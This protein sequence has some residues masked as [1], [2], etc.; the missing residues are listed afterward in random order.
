[1]TRSLRRLAV[2]VAAATTAGLLAAP[3]AAAAE[4]DVLT[5]DFGATTGAFRG[6]ASGT[7]YG[8]GDDGSPTQ[9]LINGAH[10][11]N[12]SQKPP[13]GLQHP[14][15]DALEIEDGF[16]DKHGRELAVYVQ[17]FYPDWGYHGAVRPQDTRTYDQSDG[18]WTEGGNG[19]W[20]YLEVVRHVVTR[21]ATESEHPDQYLFVLFNEPDWI[22]YAD[23]PGMK[24]QFFAD[25]TATYELV[26]EIYDEVFDGRIQ[27]RIGGPGNSRWWGSGEPADRRREADFLA[28]TAAND[29]RPDVYIWHELGGSNPDLFRQHE[30]EYRALEDLHYGTDVELPITISEWGMLPDMGVPGSM[31]RWFAAFEEEKVDAQ[32]AYWNYAGNFSENIARANGANG[33]WW[34]FKWYGDLAGSQTVRVTPPDPDDPRSLRGIGAVDADNRRATVL[35][36]GTDADV[37]LDLTGLDR[38]VFGGRVDIEVREI[39]L[40]G[41]EGVQGDPRVVRALDGV[42][43]HRDGTLADLTV[44][45]YDEDSVYQVLITPGQERDVTRSLEGQAWSTAIEAEDTRLTDARVREAG[46]QTWQASGDAD[47]AYFNQVGSRAEFTVTVPRSG[48]YRLQII[49]SAPAP[50]RH[51]LFVD[52]AF[53]TLVQYASNLT[54][55]RA[56]WIYRGSTEVEIPLS[57]GQHT[58]SLRASRDGATALPNSDITLDKFVLTD[59]TGGERTEYPASG[60]R[61][62][63]GAQ[64][65]FDGDRTA[66]SARI[67]GPGQRADLYATAWQSGYHD[68]TISYATSGAA[69]ADIS[70]NGV[71]A[72]TVTAP[73]AGSWTSTARL[74]LSQGINEIELASATG[75]H[76]STVTT[77]RVAGADTA[78]VTIEAEDADLGGQARAVTL[79]DSTGTNASGGRYVGWLGNDTAESDNVLRIERGAGFDRPGQYTVVVRYANAEVNG[80]H[81][82]N[83]QVVDRGLQISEAGTDGYA[84]TGHFRYTHHW[85]SFWERSV[86]VTLATADGALT[87]GNDEPGS[88]APDI[89]AITIAPVLLGEVRTSAA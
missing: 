12:S 30:A 13:D 15:G 5:V 27:P 10:I 50:G 38:E 65:G 21:I 62:F 88:Y 89:D 86:N 37:T 18:S 23:W 72:A 48:T 52:G 6:G 19:E 42:R 61:L 55:D 8:F 68:V 77:T 44:P 32:T 2:A 47:V 63:G 25:W 4:A 31:L 7:L 45:T 9:A 70:L 79:A 26:H 34:L 14:S 11:T 74:Y 22:W 24:D 83:P 36:G 43:V 3:G 53:G 81:D 20:D 82:Y 29:V 51:A 59:V 76:V 84:G 58:L 54:T 17:D 75:V 85:H 35:Y 87:F 46:D 40:T 69:S 1:M 66:G 33:G 49:G 67:A 71:A 28:Y 16:F 64:L 80:A 57:A 39:S 78:A 60:L 73:R 41:A 56:K